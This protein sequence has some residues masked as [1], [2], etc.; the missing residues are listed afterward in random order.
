MSLFAREQAKCHFS[1]AL[2]RNLEQHW[3]AH[4]RDV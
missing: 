4:E 3:K 1:P 2:V